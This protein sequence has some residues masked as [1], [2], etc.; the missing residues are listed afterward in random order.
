[1]MQDW[2]DQQKAEDR[3]AIRA[4]FKEVATRRRARAEQERIA[5]GLP[6]PKRGRPAKVPVGPLN[7][8]ERRLTLVK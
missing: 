2:L 1:M 6:K 5:A 8:A 4:Y 3:A 7:D